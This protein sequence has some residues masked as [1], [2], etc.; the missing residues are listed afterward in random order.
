METSRQAEDGSGN[1]F[2]ASGLLIRQAGG[3]RAMVERKLWPALLVLVGCAQAQRLVATA[4]GIDMR[5]RAWVRYYAE[6]YQLPTEFVEAIIDEESGWNPQAV[7]KKGAIGLMQLMP[8]TAARF[9]VEN[10]F[11]IEQNIHGGVA[12][13]AWLKRRFNADL[14]LVTAAYYAGEAPIQSRGLTFANADVY[15]YVRQ[16]AE[17]YRQRRANNIAIA[18]QVR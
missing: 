10:R 4:D 3:S 6:V 9:G 5:S 18:G 15:R 17:R 7:S 12:Y 14:R 16:V 11:R 1:G 2:E 8:R 13:L